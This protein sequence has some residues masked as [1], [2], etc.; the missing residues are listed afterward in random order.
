MRKA[1]SLCSRQVRSC[2]T[3]PSDMQ[4]CCRTMPLLRRAL[5]TVTWRFTPASRRPVDGGLSWVRSRCHGSAPI[6]P[7]VDPEPPAPAVHLHPRFPHGASHVAPVAPLLGKL[8]DQLQ[9]QL[10]IAFA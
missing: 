2:F 1:I 6:P 7:C 3:L 4:A 5:S 9:P 8:C 10:L